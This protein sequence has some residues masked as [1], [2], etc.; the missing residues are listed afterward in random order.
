MSSYLCA[1]P[2]PG[3]KAH[4]ACLASFAFVFR[5]A[6]GVV[7]FLVGALGGGAFFVARSGSPSVELRTQWTS[8]SQDV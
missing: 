1:L 6:F 5:A 3:S 4:L 2:S 8:C 7:A